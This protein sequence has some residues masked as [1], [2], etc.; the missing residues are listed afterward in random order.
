MLSEILKIYPEKNTEMQQPSSI[1]LKDVLENTESALIARLYEQV[2]Y[3][4][5]ELARQLG[6]GRTTLWRKLNKLGLKQ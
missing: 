3:N 4:K 2:N 5:S 1:G 6:V